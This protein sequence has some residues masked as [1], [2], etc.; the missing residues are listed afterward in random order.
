MLEIDGIKIKWT[1]HDGFRFETSDKII[2]IDPFKLIQEYN[3]KKDANLI[4]ITHNHFD[5]MSLQDISNLINEKTNIVCSYECMESL[6]KKYSK[7]KITALKPGGHTEI[8][9]IKIKG[10][11]SYNTN[12]NF[13]PKKD[14]KIGYVIH[15]NGLKIYHTGDTDI[16]PEMND[17]KPDIALVPVSG[18]YV[19]TAQ[20]ASK[21]VNDL[22]KPTKMAIPMHYNSIVG[23]IKDAEMFCDNVNICK[24]VILDLE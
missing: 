17:L 22:I 5:H 10:I 9:N 13:H 21:A 8:E 24:T 12:K 1:G 18:T 4:L 16:I 3:H 19:M 23:T 11:A 2:H 20:E 14:E 6:K 7:N 15:L